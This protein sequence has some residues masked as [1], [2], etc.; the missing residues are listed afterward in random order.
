MK[1]FRPLAMVFGLLFF[2]ILLTGLELYFIKLPT[3]D[4]VTRIL[5]IGLLTVNVL[6]L[7]TL[8]FFVG[9]NLFALYTERQNRVPGYRFRTKLVVIFVVLTMIPSAFLFFAAGGL[10]SNYLNKIFSPRMK[11]PFNKSVQLA[12]A[13]YDFE[14]DRTLKAAKD[15]V[16][17]QQPS[18]P[19]V[20]F[21]LYTEVPAGAGEMVRD[22]FK[23]K[24]GVEVVSTGEGD[25]IRAAVPAPHGVIT[26]E[27][28]LPGNISNETGKLKDLYED[29]LKLESFK[30]PLR[31]NFVLILGFLTLMMVF[32]GLWV[33]LKISRGIT[34]PIQK[35][36]MATEDVASGNLDA[37]V[38]VT[39]TDEVGLLT[40]SFNQM[41]RQL[42][43][44][45]VSIETA[46]R[47]SDRRRL[48]LENILDNINSGVLLLDPA[49]KIL[50]M[51]RVASS[52][53]GIENEDMTGKDYREL[54]AAL[55]SNELAVMVRHMEGMRIR[56][57]TREVR[58]MVAGRPVFCRVYISGLR[59]PR[60][61]R[62]IGMLVVFNDLTEVIRAQ[63]A[64]AWQ[65]VAQRMAHE[66]KNP[67]T[68]IRLNTERLFKKWQQQDEDFGPVL[69]KSVKVIISEVES[70]KRLV[71][72]FSRYGRLPDISKSK[73]NFYEFIDD[74]VSLYRGFRAIDIN[75]DIS[76]GIP[77]VM[78]DAEQFK[79]VLI[80]IM[81]NAIKA[82][83]NEGRLG[84][85][86]QAQ[87]DV[88]SIEISD[89][90]PGISD[91][92]KDKLFIPYFSRRKGGTGL[93]LA[94][95]GKI[96]AD[97]GGRIK[98]AN[99]MP[100]GAVFRIEVPL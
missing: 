97:H 92:E 2:V 15:K 96:V 32:I 64:L 18:Y 80:N 56:E 10:A 52:I 65:E 79:R 36:A 3:V 51:N 14:R 72:E 24:E 85:F 22:A 17:G 5:L 28:A 60:E 23:G 70:L 83:N 57:I 61:A 26:A 35:L 75:M 77:D 37:Q 63:K 13:F 98:V 43:E 73:V 68:P 93:G 9:K 29:Y 78:L 54:V 20:S 33:S 39:S 53:L 7:L 6:A 86:A 50:T 71:D 55:D 8:M 49:G 46:Y 1:I 58:I 90:G 84:V 95:A 44:S 94:I 30:E 81:D 42:K 11:E 31:L 27:T 21:H 59:D 40:G 38:D 41:V 87:G 69:E 19:A 100:S 48:Y 91:E 12:Q 89:T 66:I 47:E 34:I 4:I 76:E 67:L 45:K 25:I 62:S 16:S 99:N 82:M 88:L 74:I